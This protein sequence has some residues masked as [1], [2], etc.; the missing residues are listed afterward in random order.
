MCSGIYSAYTIHTWVQHWHRFCSHHSCTET[1]LD[2][3][4]KRYELNW[5]SEWRGNKKRTFKTSIIPQKAG[6]LVN[7]ASDLKY[8]FDVKVNSNIKIDRKKPSID[9]RLAPE[10]NEAT[11]PKFYHADI[12]NRACLDIGLFT[13]FC[14]EARRPQPGLNRGNVGKYWFIYSHKLGLVTPK[15]VKIFGGH[16]RS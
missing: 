2:M 15:L 16:W 14:V 13:L 12:R 10:P 1:S 3:M 9:R 8:I 5:M 7:I 6:A 4:Q 11:F